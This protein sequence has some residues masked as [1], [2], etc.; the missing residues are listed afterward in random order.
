MKFTEALDQM[1][2][3][4]EGLLSLLTPEMAETLIQ[5]VEAAPR[6]FGCAT[7]RSGFILR[8]FLMRLMHL[9]FTVFMV[10]ETITPRVQPGDLLLVMSGSGETAQ[11]REILRRANTVGARTLALT[12]CPD[13]TIGREAQTAII[14]P[15]TTKLTLAHEPTSLQCPGSL[16]EQATFLFLE[17]VVLLFYQRRL[18]HDRGEM[19][20]RH[21]DLE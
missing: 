21:T 15:G 5:E 14:I 2:G 1:R 6:I 4:L 20:S 13:S 16:F 3:E 9:G 11:P 19:L 7:G 8:G 10:G 17:A 12:A 18:G